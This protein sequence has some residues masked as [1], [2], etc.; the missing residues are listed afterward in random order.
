MHKVHQKFKPCWRIHVFMGKASVNIS[1]RHFIMLCFSYPV[2]VCI[3]VA[4]S[5]LR[6]GKLKHSGVNVDSLQHCPSWHHSLIR[7][8]WSL[9]VWFEIVD[10]C[11]S[12]QEQTNKTLVQMKCQKR[13]TLS[14]GGTNHSVQVMLKNYTQKNLYTG[15]TKKFKFSKRVHQPL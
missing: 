12:H 11:F 15:K 13:K 9:Q 3:H 14:R 1:A 7:V 10:I 5:P 6:L 4:R 2:P 8:V